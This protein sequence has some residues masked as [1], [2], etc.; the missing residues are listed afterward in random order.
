MERQKCFHL[1]KLFVNGILKPVGYFWLK[2]VAC[3]STILSDVT[4]EWILYSPS[5]SVRLWLGSPDWFPA[6]PVKLCVLCWGSCPASA[7]GERAWWSR[8]HVT[9][10]SLWIRSRPPAARPPIGPVGLPVFPKRLCGDEPL[11]GQAG[12]SPGPPALAEPRLS[13]LMEKMKELIWVCWTQASIII[14]LTRVDS[15]L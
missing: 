9:W 4:S 1:I 5:K 10:A 3:V 14:S 6:P 11:Q 13:H 7:A 8:K 15:I 12:F 2:Y